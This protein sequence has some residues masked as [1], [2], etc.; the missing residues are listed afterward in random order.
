VKIPI[1]DTSYTRAFV[2]GTR[3]LLVTRW[4]ESYQVRAYDFSR[5]GCMALVRAGSGKEERM[6]MPNLG[7]VWSPTGPDNGRLVMKSLGDSIV[8]CVD[9]GSLGEVC[10]WELA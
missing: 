8:T 10:I 4:Q 5:Q 2:F 3:V 6:V 1:N 7:K 9:A